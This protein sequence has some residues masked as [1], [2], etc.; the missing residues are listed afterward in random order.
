MTHL[1][2]K[3]PT[4]KLIQTAQWA[5]LQTAEMLKDAGFTQFSPVIKGDKPDLVVF[6]GG[7]DV[8]PALYHESCLSR[9]TINKKRDR[10]EITQFEE[11]KDRPKV[12]ICRGGQFLNVMSGGEMWQDV[13]NHTTNHGLVDL[14]TRDDHFYDYMEVTSTHHQMMRPSEDGE[15]LAIAWEAT[16]FHS[17]ARTDNKTE[18]PARPIFD[19]EVVFYEKTNSLCFQPHPE[20][21]DNDT[22]RLFFDYI[23]WF[24]DMGNYKGK[25]A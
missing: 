6:L 3:Q 16:R 25:K 4:F 14:L 13:D 15:V 12:G 21:R 24:W 18:L 1:L 7:E 5:G 11:Y 9:T 23:K 2:N 8:D 22:R 19:T 20:Y 17:G 10:F